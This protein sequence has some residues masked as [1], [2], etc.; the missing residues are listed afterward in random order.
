LTFRAHGFTFR[1]NES[2]GFC[3]R[4]PLSDNPSAAAKTATGEDA[5]TDPRSWS[6]EEIERLHE[7]WR[8]PDLTRKQIAARLNRS[9]NSVSVQAS[10]LG[11][12]R[13]PNTS[14]GRD[15]QAQAGEE[16]PERECN[17][18]SRR[19]RPSS[20]YVRFC[21]KCRAG[22]EVRQAGDWYIVGV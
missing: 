18:C 13:R 20:R 10:R 9:V 11:L 6:V 12:G 14:G 1:E 15:A 17:I 8:L 7:L 19:F 3:R 16:L 5:S 2:Q 4:G 21:P 22:D